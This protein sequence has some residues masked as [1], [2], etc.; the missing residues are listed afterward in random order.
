[1]KSNKTFDLIKSYYPVCVI[2]SSQKMILNIDYHLIKDCSCAYVKLYQN[3]KHL[4]TLRTNNNTEL[5]RNIKK[6][7]GY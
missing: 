6:Y 4:D 5:L 1:M 2:E 7:L 3:G